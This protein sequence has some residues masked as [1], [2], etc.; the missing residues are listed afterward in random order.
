MSL[1]SWDFLISCPLSFILYL[2]FSAFLL[3]P[4]CRKSTLLLPC[5]IVGNGICARVSHFSEVFFVAVFFCVLCGDN[6]CFVL[7][8][9]TITDVEYMMLGRL[10]TV[11]EEGHILDLN[12]WN[13]RCQTKAQ[14]FHMLP[15]SHM[16]VCQEYT[17]KHY[18]LEQTIGNVDQAI[19]SCSR[20][21][22]CGFGGYFC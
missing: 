3:L 18:L 5:I 14:R 12:L 10:I 4:P 21:A 11:Y 1:D 9:G 15:F 7:C 22:W 6:S 13:Q 17:V 16:G 8:L 19:Y 20:E 2:I